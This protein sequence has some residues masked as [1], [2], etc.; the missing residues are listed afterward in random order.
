MPFIRYWN[1]G[2]HGY[3]LNVA[4]L[5][6]NQAQAEASSVGGYL[7]EVGTE[8]ENNF[9]KSIL[10]DELSDLRNDFSFDYQ[11]RSLAFLNRDTTAADG[12]GS[13]YVWMGGTDNQNEGR[14]IWAKT[15]EAIN[16][17]RSE[18]GVWSSRF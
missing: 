15:G 16:L 8:A 12:G 17:S 1:F 5:N 10:S 2:G 13:A 18:W 14:W 11:D 9:L 4:N 6:W 3:G 7:V